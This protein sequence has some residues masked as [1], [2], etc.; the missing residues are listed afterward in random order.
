MKTISVFSLLILNA[1]LMTASHAAQDQSLIQTTRKNQL[2]N[3]A[4]TEQAA[5]SKPAQQSAQK[6]VLPLDHG[7]HAV[8]TP[9]VNEQRRLHAAEQEKAAVA[10]ARNGAQEQ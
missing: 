8:V 4:K 5:A 9:W 10:V 3:D 7:P 2:A 1:A 6:R